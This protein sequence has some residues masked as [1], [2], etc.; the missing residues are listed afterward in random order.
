[1]SGDMPLAQSAAAGL[2]REALGVRPGRGGFGRKRPLS[3][4]NSTS[5]LGAF[6]ALDDQTP[7]G[8]RRLNP[9]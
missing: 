2:W 5:E 8:Q 6:Q 4:S 3:G 7:A 9:L 1:M